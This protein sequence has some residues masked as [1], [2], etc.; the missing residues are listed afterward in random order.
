MVVVKLMF[1][2]ALTSVPRIASSVSFI[3]VEKFHSFGE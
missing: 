3:N 2:L 1:C